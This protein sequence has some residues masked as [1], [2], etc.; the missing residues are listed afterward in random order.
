[1]YRPRARSDR[2]GRSLDFDK[3]HSTIAC[4]QKLSARILVA[5]QGGG[6]S[7]DRNSLMVA[8]SRYCDASLLAG[9][10]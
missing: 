3:A 4:D 9:L 10:D 6:L 7:M 8:V 2:F 5:E 1:L